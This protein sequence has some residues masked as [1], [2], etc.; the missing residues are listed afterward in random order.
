MADINTPEFAQQ[1]MSYNTPDGKPPDHRQL[2][3]DLVSQVHGPQAAIITDSALKNQDKQIKE[4]M[5][6]H[7][8]TVQEILASQ[9]IDLNALANPQKGF[10]GRW[11][12][13]FNKQVGNVT[14]SDIL[15]NLIKASEITKNYQQLNNLNPQNAIANISRLNALA[16]Q[17]GLDNYQFD[18]T[19]NGQLVLSPKPA[20][21]N[22]AIMAENQAKQQ[23][24]L[25]QNYRAL[26]TKGLSYKSGGIG[27][28][29][30]KVNQ[31][32][33]LRT[34]IDQTYD[35]KTGE[36]NIPSSAYGELAL[37]MA[38][39]L[40]PNGQVGVELAKK[41]Q[42]GTASEDLG[43]LLV[44][45]GA[46]PS[47]V[48]GPTQGV[49]KFLRE[50]IDRQGSTAEK[51]RNKYFDQI[52]NMAPKGLA[53]DRKD[54]IDNENFGNSFNEY[55]KTAPDKVNNMSQGWNDQ[56]EARYQELLKKRGGK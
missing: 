46:D 19:A 53:Q 17:N 25:E 26:W 38:R 43:K 56:K 28:Q 34:L 40:S 14:N 45:A 1:N 35:P 37:G 2:L 41:L 20:S 24:R 23:D 12:D 27:V 52:K 30:N 39:L 42:Q 8:K 15:G 32:I 21:L 4:A 22:D 11:Q 55:L 44:Y 36:Y 16:K 49:I 7:G 31:A 3:L 48:K 33:D 50:S 6:D 18:Q 54:A 13:N 47:K 5:V 51:L 10:L 29:D 9:G